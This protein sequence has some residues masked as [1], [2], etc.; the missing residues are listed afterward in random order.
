MI[1]SINFTT[2]TIFKNES[3]NCN[4]PN[5]CGAVKAQCATQ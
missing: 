2:N 3:F 5:V 1:N 4:Y